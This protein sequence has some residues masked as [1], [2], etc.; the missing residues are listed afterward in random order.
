MLG[1]QTQ[2]FRRGQLGER[3]C[4][5]ALPDVIRGAGRMPGQDIDSPHKQLTQG[6]LRRC[7][8]GQ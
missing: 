4:N 6:A 3:P 8:E 7:Q 5:C 2:R 1:D